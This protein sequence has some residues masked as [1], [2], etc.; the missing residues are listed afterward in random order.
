MNPADFE[1]ADA[2][3]V[4]GVEDEFA[5][6]A[7]AEEVEPFFASVFFIRMKSET[8]PC[9]VFRSISMKVIAGKN[10]KILI[11]FFVSLIRMCHSN[12]CSPVIFKFLCI[13]IFVSVFFVVSLFIFLSLVNSLAI[14]L[15]PYYLACI[16]WKKTCKAFSQKPNMK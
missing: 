6:V 5:G 12:Q 16:K 8:K 2:D 10:I 4:D 9:F 3:V 13:I 11:H 7:A 14:F 15:S 1:E